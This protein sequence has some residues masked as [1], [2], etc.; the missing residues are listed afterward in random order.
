MIYSIDEKSIKADRI[1]N[2]GKEIKK[3]LY[4]GPR[5]G[6][7]ADSAHTIPYQEDKQ[8]QKLYIKKEEYKKPGSQLPEDVQSKLIKLKIDKLPQA[9]I[10]LYQIKVDFTGDVHSKAVIA[11]KDTKGKWQQGYTPKF[12]KKNAEAKW[13]RIDKYRSKIESIKSKINKGL[14]MGSGPPKHQGLTILAIITETGLR[15]GNWGSMEKYGHYGVSTLRKEHVSFK[16]GV[17]I[18]NFIG[19]AGKE[20]TATIKDKDTIASLKYYYNKKI[21]GGES[22]T[23][24]LFSINALDFVDN[25]LPKGMKVKDL[26]TIKA[27]IEAEKVLKSIDEPPPFTGDIKKD[28]K[29][30]AKALLTASTKV[31]GVLN[32]TPSIAKASYIHPNVFK[33]WLSRIN[34][35]KELG[36]LL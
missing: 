10:P 31:A 27:T 33:E 35:P 12:H 11:W 28:K 6:K 19:K 15:P 18:L 20:N 5:G 9:D 2:K 22:D 16:Q 8:K 34:T 1:K 3:A 24:N 26:R 30:L 23:S 29:L 13:K 14:K 21:E 17:C 7:W 4:I 25:V 32:N 36:A